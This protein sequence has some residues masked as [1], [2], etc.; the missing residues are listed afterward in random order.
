MVHHTGSPPPPPSTHGAHGAHWPNIGGWGRESNREIVSF[1]FVR[2]CVRAVCWGSG[3]TAKKGSRHFL[4]S[5]MP[6]R[7]K[8]PPFSVFPYAPGAV[9][10]SLEL[11]CFPFRFE[12]KSKWTRSDTDLKRN[13]NWGDIEVKPNWHRSEIE[14]KS[15]L[16]RSELEVYPKWNR[17]DIEV[18][19]KWQFEAKSKVKPK[20]NRSEIE[21]KSKWARSETKVKSKWN[22]SEIE[23]KPK[24]HLSEI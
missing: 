15:K 8:I 11:Q 6:S 5:L 21:V 23:V 4:F 22:R 3:N 10:I 2:A 1:R 16:N 7:R 9:S 13:W 17:S 12:L 24:R 14:V 20:C 18:K 19:P